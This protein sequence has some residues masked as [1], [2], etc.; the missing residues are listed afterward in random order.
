[1][2]TEELNFC[3]LFFLFASMRE[4]STANLKKKKTASFNA[5]LAAILS[6][7][8]Q[9]ISALISATPDRVCKALQTL[10]MSTFF[11]EARIRRALIHLPECVFAKSPFLLLLFLEVK[12][13]FSA[14]GFSNQIK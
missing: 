7:L 1:M 12:L 13:L 4:T 9:T 10:R 14:G 2:M 11:I 3:S 6:S 8:F 5:I